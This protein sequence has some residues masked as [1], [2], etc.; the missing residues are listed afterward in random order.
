MN[1]KDKDISLGWLLVLGM[2]LAG[3]FAMP[4]EDPQKQQTTRPAT[5]AERMCPDDPEH[6]WWK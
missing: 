1:P 5:T 2:A 4:A 6:C 3:L